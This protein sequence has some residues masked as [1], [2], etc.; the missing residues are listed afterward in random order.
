MPHVSIL[1]TTY[2]SE[3]YLHE[4]IDSLLKQTYTNWTLYI[5]DDG[6][7]DR[8]S[9]IIDDYTTQYTRVVKLF[10][11][12]ARQGAKNNFL[13]LLSE[14][15]SDYF[16]F[17]DHDDV[18]LPN[19][20]EKSITE[21]IKLERDNPLVPIIVHSDL[22]VVDKNLDIIS[23]SFFE[24][25]GVNPRILLSSINHLSHSNCVTGC[26]MIINRLA[27]EVSFPILPEAL[28]HDSWIALSVFH[29]NGIIHCIYE[30]LILYRQHDNNAL[31]AISKNQNGMLRRLSYIHKS[32][33]ANFKQY[34]MAKK[35]SNISLLK[36]LL[37]R[38]IYIRKNKKQ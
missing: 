16:M 35:I 19:K 4:L 23:N 33:L 9:Q 20:I 30:P 37:Y 1:L 7:I 12:K 26:T 24:Y 31:G 3:R 25:A 18:W 5:V 34:K 2:N 13:Y 11:R 22:Y 38:I 21:I 17:C 6:S 29:A 36:F 32:C 28:M 10:N 27:K 14:V 15:E 8:T